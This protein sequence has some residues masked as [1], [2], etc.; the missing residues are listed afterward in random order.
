MRAFDQQGDVQQ[1][2]TVSA[3]V[4]SVCAE[5]TMEF[6]DFSA[7]RGNDLRSIVSPGQRWCLC[8]SRWGC[9]FCPYWCWKLQMCSTHRHCKQASAWWVAVAE[10]ILLSEA[11]NEHC[12]LTYQ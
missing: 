2:V 9:M 3:G 4:H 6:L 7:S 1:E 10:S 11:Q 12:C 8:V 5:C